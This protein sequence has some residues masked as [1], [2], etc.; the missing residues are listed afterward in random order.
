[1]KSQLFDAIELREKEGQDN[2]KGTSEDPVELVEP[3][4]PSYRLYHEGSAGMPGITTSTLYPG[5]LGKS[6]ETTLIADSLDK[7]L[8]VAHDRLHKVGKGLMVVSGY[9]SPE[10]QQTKFAHLFRISLPNGRESSPA[11]IMEAGIQADNIGSVAEL[12]EDEAYEAQMES[13]RTNTDL[14]A[15]LVGYMTSKSMEPTLKRYLTFLANAG[16]TE[17]LTLNYATATTVHNS[18]HSA[19][20]VLTD[21]QGNILPTGRA[22]DVPSSTQPWNALETITPSKLRAELR[23]NP[24]LERFM[25][26]S[27]VK[28]INT[29]AIEEMC[30]N[31]RAL[32]NAV[33][34][35][36][37]DG[38]TDVYAGE[39]GH[40]SIRRPEYP[41]RVG[42]EK[43]LANWRHANPT[44]PR[45]TLA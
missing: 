39:G 15:D 41:N 5:K 19:N 34:R 22:L 18:A 8:R 28:T 6:V 13:L 1:M 3:S 43:S 10:D 16:W 40:V 26:E 36:T 23:G 7:A 42:V 17:G 9:I 25:R 20:V 14:C 38:E 27:G 2:I 37:L 29:A 33:M 35:G 21:D 4:V 31:N 44:W 32:F 12:V 45:H 24:L 30:N 11:L